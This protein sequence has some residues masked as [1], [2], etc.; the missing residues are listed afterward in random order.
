MIGRLRGLLA[1]KH[2]DRVVLDVAGVGYEVAVTPR[3]LLELPGVGE[4]AVLHTHLHV[5]EDNLAL[6]GFAGED[7]R[8]LFRLLIGVS[9][10]GPK[11]GLAILGTMSADDLRRAVLTE[12]A[13]ALT[14]VPGIGKRSAQKLMLE[15][16][17][18]LDLPDA[19][20]PSSGAAAAEV[21]EALEGLGY[22]ASEI[23]AALQS[24]EPDLAVEDMLRA[25]LQQLGRQ[26]EA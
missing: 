17:P 20:L 12:D 10:V 4:E 24:I 2:G 21:R 9:G 26:A 16:R 14:L 25:A 1:A 13:A 7:H 19:E 23:R 15:L 22:Q 8:D 11:V 5:R 6:F 3:T 18:K